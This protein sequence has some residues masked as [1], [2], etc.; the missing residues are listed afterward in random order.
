MGVLQGQRMLQVFHIVFTFAHHSQ[1]F[2]LICLNILL[3][4]RRFEVVLTVAHHSQQFRLTCL[5]ILLM[6]QIFKIV[7]IIAKIL[8]YQHQYS[9]F[10]HY[11]QSSQV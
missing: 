3:M 11:K 7:F 2:Q 8:H 6:L 1:Q 5:N 4:L 10:R 9:T